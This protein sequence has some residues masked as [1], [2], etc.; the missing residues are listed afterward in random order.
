MINNLFIL[1]KLLEI[2]MNRSLP[3]QYHDV[4]VDF[5]YFRFFYSFSAYI[6]VP[7]IVDLGD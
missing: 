4:H 2:C 7:V 5:S 6:H 1:L 3:A